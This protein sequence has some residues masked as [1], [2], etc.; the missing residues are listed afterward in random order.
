MRS[1]FPWTSKSGREIFFKRSK[2]LYVSTVV[3]PIR[4]QGR[5]FHHKLPWK[6][7]CCRPVTRHVA[8]RLFKGFQFVLRINNT[9]FKRLNFCDSEEACYL[10]GTSLIKPYGKVVPALCLL[11]LH[12]TKACRKYGGKT[13]G[14]RW[15]GK[16]AVPGAGLHVKWPT[17][18]NK[19]LPLS[20]TKA[21]SPGPYLVTLLMT[22]SGS[23]R[24]MLQQLL[25]LFSLLVAVVMDLKTNEY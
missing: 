8:H 11:K 24:P 25:I 4:S 14:I 6:I 2:G 19:F 1:I 5:N 3:Q 23:L 17:R 16:W 22:Y 18:R 20:G 15:I 13:P 9:F 12:I 21:P 7:Q 10:S